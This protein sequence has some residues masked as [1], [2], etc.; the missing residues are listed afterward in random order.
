MSA[1]TCRKIH[2]YFRC[3]DRGSEN[4]SE[5]SLASPT[6]AN[7]ENDHGYGCENGRG[8][9]SDHSCVSH[10]GNGNANVHDYV[11]E[12]VHGNGRDHDRDDGVQSMPCQSSSP[13]D[14]NH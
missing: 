11:H 14:L 9:A 2:A 12:S 10:R 7:R 8:H 4:G 6:A 5:P 1:R 3:R 13:R